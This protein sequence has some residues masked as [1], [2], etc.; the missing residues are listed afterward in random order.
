MFSIHPLIGK[1]QGQGLISGIN[2]KQRSNDNQRHNKSFYWDLF[3]IGELK[4]RVFLQLVF[5][6]VISWQNSA[7]F[8]QNS[9]S[10]AG[11]RMIFLSRFGS[12]CPVL[13]KKKRKFKLPGHCSLNN[14]FPNARLGSFLSCFVKKTTKK[15]KLKL[16]GH[17]SHW[18]PQSSLGPALGKMFLPILTPAKKST[19]KIPKES[20]GKQ[21][22]VAAVGVL[23]LCTSRGRYKAFK[24]GKDLRFGGNKGL[25]SYRGK[26]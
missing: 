22:N 11:W 6:V 4:G 15:R 14:D 17:C 25:M 1:S 21:P 10:E 9:E 18:V 8:P 19:K 20:K 2:Q 7:V 16:P 5:P 13:L 26:K 24:G 3:E 23:L 12:F